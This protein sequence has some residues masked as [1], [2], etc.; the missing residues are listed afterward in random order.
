MTAEKNE[1]PYR[2]RLCV[3]RN[4]ASDADPALITDLQA[5]N[6][7][8][9]SDATTKAI[10]LMDQ[11]RQLGPDAPRK[12]LVGRIFELKARVPSGGVR[13]Y[14]AR[15]NATEFLMGRAE[16]KKEDEADP[17]LLNWFA[18]VLADLDQG[19]TNLLR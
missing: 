15:L 1:P 14:F 4:D 16:C 3:H 19:H 10:E 5:L 2:T 12:H 18:E 13:V 8:G 9:Q 6:Q 7:R 17:R 11:L